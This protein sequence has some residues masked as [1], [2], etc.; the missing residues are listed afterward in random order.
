MAFDEDT[1]TPSK[2]RCLE[3]RIG[4]SPDQASN[5]RSSQCPDEGGK[6]RSSQSPDE[7]GKSF[8]SQSPDEGGKGREG[9]SPDV[10]GK[11]RSGQSHNGGGKGRSGGKGRG[12]QSLEGS[13]GQGG[14]SKSTAASQLKRAMNE[15]MVVCN[16]VSNYK[17]F[18][19]TDP[20]C[21]YANNEFYLKP[22]L[23][24]EKKLKELCQAPLIQQ[25]SLSGVA[26]IGKELGWS[27][28]KL[29]Q[30]CVE[31]ISELK[32][33]VKTLQHEYGIVIAD[34]K[35]RVQKLKD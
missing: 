9:Q 23:G 17:N 27:D 11:G 3:G 6:G 31:L 22:L 18:I 24:A 10:G 4:H 35:N 26:N 21:A 29:E 32:P 25:A 7:G 28:Q 15:A 8:N 33:A 34:R 12:G 20:L 5:G 13:G 16:Q 14:G 30:T 19:R 2:K 1:T